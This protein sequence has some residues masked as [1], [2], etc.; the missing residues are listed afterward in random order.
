MV[1]L[2]LISTQ[3]WV[4]TIFIFWVWVTSLSMIFSCFI[5][6]H[7]NYMKS[8]FWIVLFYCVNVSHIFFFELLILCLNFWSSCFLPSCVEITNSPPHIIY[9][10]LVNEF[11][12]L[13]MSGNHSNN[14][15]VPQ[16]SFSSVAMSNSFCCANEGFQV[17]FTNITSIL[18]NLLL[19]IIYFSFVEFSDYL[20][21][22]E[23]ISLLF[24]LLIFPFHSFSF[25][26]STGRQCSSFARG[27]WFSDFLLFLFFWQISANPCFNPL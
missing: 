10:L 25:W 11:M 18:V 3:K 23:E 2:Q 20:N 14:W 13:F 15:A 16:P 21:I 7:A 24:H 1:N 12:N 19:S 6:F 8:L 9:M 17:L 22:F 27:K 26:W 4:P 5:Y